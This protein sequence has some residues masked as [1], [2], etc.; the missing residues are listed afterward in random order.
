MSQKMYGVVLWADPGDQKAVIWCEDHGDL[1]FYHDTVTSAHEGVS[2][3]AGDLIQ[4]D[5]TQDENLRLA[6]NPRRLVQR[7][8]PDL[9]QTL[10]SANA[11]EGGASRCRDAAR[12]SGK[13]VSFPDRRFLAETLKAS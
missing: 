10:R 3:D 6:R 2:L 4:F 12:P 9:A 5:L 11:A 13:V 8:Y 7:Q 1:A